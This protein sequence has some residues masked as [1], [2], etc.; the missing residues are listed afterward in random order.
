MEQMDDGE[1]LRGIRQRS[2]APAPFLLPRLIPPFMRL[3]TC[4]VFAL[5]S[6]RLWSAPDLKALD[7]Y[8]QN[9]LRDWNVPGF[10][11]VVVEDCETVFEK[12][13]GVREAGRLEK[14]DPDTLFAIASNTKAFTAAGLAMLAK[15]KKIRWDDRVQNYLPWFEVFGDPWISHETRIDDLLCH[16][17]GFRTF[18]GDLLW[19]GSS[20]STEEVLRRARY[21]KPQ[22]S[23]RRGYG[24]SNLMVMAAGE[25]LEKA[26]GQPWETFL[27]ERILEPLG[28]TNTVL[29]VSELKSRS[30]VATPHDGKP[31]HP[32]PIAW[33]PW[34]NMQAAGG[35]I[36][37]VSDLSRWLK[38]QL[39]EG[40]LDGREFWTSD[41]AWKMWTLHNSLPISEKTRKDYPETSLTGAGLGWFISDYNGTLIARHGG[42]YDGMY[43]HTVLA[44]RKKIGVVV[45]SNSMTDL[46]RVV[47]FY[48][49]D[50]FLGNHLR[51]WS[52]EALVKAHETQAKKEKKEAEDLAKR[53]PDTKPSLPLEKYAGIYSGPMYGDA[54]VEFKDG[55]L[56]LALLPTA[57]L[58]A[59]LIHWQHDVF[60]I[61]W[62]RNFAFFGMGKA[63]FIL[64][65]SSEAAEL[66]LD[67][68]NED[69]WFDEL[70]FKKN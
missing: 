26:S 38:L 33:E 51:D 39:S 62:D 70:E 61:K 40:S 22:Y 31:G 27:R 32:E 24:Y 37:S 7:D 43:S 19:W 44:P 18:S 64:N 14:V 8:C 20:Y 6:L 54:K 11:I 56:R 21:L 30:N 35:I 45:L 16:R 47:A 29:R 10:A 25:A 55:K 12:G 60:Q 41:Q 15:E 34:D 68:P 58:T 23:F 5:F 57:K 67:V 65:N 1:Q 63:Q 69:F 59:E 17:I 53:L 46:P 48:A 28:M 13:L 2:V 3:L 66:K 52:A 42:G 50:H 4:L 49:L 9:A 36:S